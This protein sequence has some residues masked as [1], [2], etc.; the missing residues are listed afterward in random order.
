M[1]QI[2]PQTL[3]E[4]QTLAVRGKA[5]AEHIGSW[6]AAAYRAVGDHAA[7]VGASF[8][9][10]PYA[11]YRPLDTELC[12]FEIEAGFPIESPAAGSSDGAV[13]SATLPGGRAATTWHVGP[14][15]SLAC[16]HT[17]ID[18]WI[19][20]RGGATD[21]PCWEVYYSDPVSESDASRWRTEVVKVY[22]L[23]TVGFGYR[24]PT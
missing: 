15:D 23:P 7:R 18:T 24:P 1:Y 11:R 5:D 16:A 2:T 13:E 20:E 19:V 4:Q 10:P 12:E 17:A 8:S 3:P 6:L 14:Y 9:G 21:G 22:G